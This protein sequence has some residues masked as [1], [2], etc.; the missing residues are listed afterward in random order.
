VLDLA[1]APDLD[2]LGSLTTL[3]EKGIIQ[4][5][6]AVGVRDTPLLGAAE[7]HALRGH[8]LRGRPHRQALVAKIVL[9]GTGPK[10]GRWF[11]RSLPG[12][13]PLS[14]DPASLRSSFGTLGTLE[15]SEVLKVDFVFAPIAEA[16]RP[17]WRPFLSSALGALMLEDTEAV[18]KLAR[19]CAFELRLPLVIASGPASGSLNATEV[20]P[21]SLRGAPGGAV[22]IDTDAA[23]AVRTLLL[24]ALQTPV[25]ESPE[26]VA[27][28]P[29]E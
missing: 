1:D 7:I 23:H 28:Q 14:N 4:K 22:I 27:L 6:D 29:G 16:A 10:S 11:L 26:T 15:I 2:I 24:A 9:C 25:Q 18:M 12:L 21:T 8:L 19:Y 3:L 20:L 5:F 13:K 17:L